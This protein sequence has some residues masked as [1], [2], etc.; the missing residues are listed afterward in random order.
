[1]GKRFGEEMRR[2]M[3]P[4]VHLFDPVGGVLGEPTLHAVPPI[5]LHSYPLSS[6]QHEYKGDRARRARGRVMR[7]VTCCFSFRPFIIL[8]VCI[9][10]LPF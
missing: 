10:K 2:S 3:D 7:C 8:H 4:C 6:M 1:M 9:N 5:F